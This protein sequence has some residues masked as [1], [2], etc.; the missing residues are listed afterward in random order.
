MRAFLVA[1]YNV[2]MPLWV[3]AYTLSGAKRAARLKIQRSEPFPGE[4]RFISYNRPHGYLSFASEGR[5][6][7]QI[8]WGF[9]YEAVVAMDRCTI[10]RRV[11]H[12]L[13]YTVTQPRR[14]VIAYGE[15]LTL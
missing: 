7:S 15:I 2:E 8:D 6:G 9:V 13:R 4:F 10:E 12:A 14:G 1:N 11:Y 3:L 5:T